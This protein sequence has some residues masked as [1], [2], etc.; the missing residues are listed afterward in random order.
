MAVGNGPELLARMDALSVILTVC[1]VVSAATA[2]LTDR[3]G[4]LSDKAG[5]LPDRLSVRGFSSTGIAIIGSLTTS[6]D[7]LLVIGMFLLSMRGLTPLHSGT[8]CCSRTLPIIKLSSLRIRGLMPLHS[9]DHSTPEVSR[10]FFNVG[11]SYLNVGRST[12]GSELNI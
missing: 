4:F 12:A 9:G 8:H 10:S 3:V 1:R 11:R 6:G 7:H 2:N 5:S